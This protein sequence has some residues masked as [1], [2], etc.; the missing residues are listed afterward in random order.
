MA[1]APDVHWPHGSCWSSNHSPS[2]LKLTVKNGC[3][4]PAR[5]EPADLDVLFFL[6]FSEELVKGRTMRRPMRPHD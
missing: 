1:V 4:L 3:V 5:E 2:S 6:C